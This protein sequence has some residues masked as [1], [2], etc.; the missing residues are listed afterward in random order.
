V[1]HVEEFFLSRMSLPTQ[2]IEKASSR[3]G[4]S[5]NK[6]SPGHHQ[7]GQSPRPISPELLKHPLAATAPYN[8]R[9]ALLPMGWYSSNRGNPALWVSL[10]ALGEGD[11]SPLP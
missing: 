4:E 5:N 8:M 9:N 11:C 2:H 1:G 6:D 10:A 3:P 7:R